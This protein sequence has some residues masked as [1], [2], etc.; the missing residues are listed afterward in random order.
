MNLADTVQ[1]RLDRLALATGH[2]LSID[3]PDGRLIA[4][5]AQNHSTDPV[6]IA[7]I[8]ARYVVPEVQAWQNRHGIAEAIGPVEVPANPELGMAARL[9][10]PIRQEHGCV[11]YLWV[12]LSDSPVDGAAL[13]E[14]VRFAGDIAPDL[15]GGRSASRDRNTLIRGV[16]GE[17][18]TAEVFDDLAA[19]MPSLLGTR[20]QIC[21]VVSATSERTGVSAFSS[22]E[23]LRLTTGL[24]SAL[25]RHADYVGSF[26]GAT[27][28]IVL[29]RHRPAG[30]VISQIVAVANPS[31]SAVVGISDPMAFELDAVRGAHGQALAAAELAA[32]DPALPNPLTWSDLGPYRRLLQTSVESPDTTLAALENAGASAAMLLRTLETYLDL[33]GDAQRTAA[34]LHLHRTSLYY[35]LGRIG[36]LLGVDLDDGLTRLDLHLALKSHR[37]ARRTLG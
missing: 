9:C 11:G 19:A 12:L 21:A 3:A 7:A 28:A 36:A 13:A 29:V 32:L 8:L 33:G 23:F 37:L 18:A 17:S 27:H 26:V 20:I 24:P 30:A 1:D 35:R 10:V 6:R 22:T 2:S 25:D 15:G 16:L 5:S 14:I 34:Q 31:G 4:Y